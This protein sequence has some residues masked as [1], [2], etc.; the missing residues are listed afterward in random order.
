MVSPYFTE[1][2]MDG[3]GRD[4]EWTTNLR[5]YFLIEQPAYLFPA[6]S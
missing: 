5:F 3:R 2:G 4:Y 6:L 1:P